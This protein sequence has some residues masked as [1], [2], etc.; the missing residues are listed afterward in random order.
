MAQARGD[1]TGTA[2]GKIGPLNVRRQTLTR[3]SHRF[4]VKNK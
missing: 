4:Q 1:G 2:R 3:Y